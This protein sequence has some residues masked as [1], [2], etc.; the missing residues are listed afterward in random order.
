MP[1]RRR[2]AVP[3]EQS[4]HEAVLAPRRCRGASASSLVLG[5]ADRRRLVCGDRGAEEVHRRRAWDDRTGADGGRTGV[6][7]KTRCDIRTAHSTPDAV[8]E[9]RVQYDEVRARRR[10]LEEQIVGAVETACERPG[11]TCVA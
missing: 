2:R 4:L 1:V 7:A 10:Q 8:H 5:E 3:G 11:L 9:L 6:D